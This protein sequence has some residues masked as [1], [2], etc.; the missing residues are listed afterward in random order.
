MITINL[1]DQGSAKGRPG[2]PA[3]PG[4]RPSAGGGG[5]GSLLTILALL[6]ALGI[7]GAAGWFGYQNYS[8]AHK[9]FAAIKGEHD[10]VQAE[11]ANKENEA[12]SVRKY[13]E[14]VENQLDVLNSLDP[15]DR[16]LWA[17]KLNML[18]GLMPTNV[19]LA[20]IDVQ[21]K[22][23]MV[24]TEQSKQA[25]AK[26]QKMKKAEKDKTKE[27][28]IVTKP[29]ISY[30]VRLTGLASGKDNVEQFDNMM[31]FHRAMTEFETVAN[32]GEARRFM[33]NFNPNI[34]FEK[35]EATVYEGVP[36][37]QFVFKLTTKLMGQDN[38]EP[39]G[40]VATPAKTSKKV[41]A[42]R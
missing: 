20:E 39:A 19:F 42:A 31:K 2:K 8:S 25:R 32:S 23:T 29:V 13:R 1:L 10:K 16:I 21:E 36:V 18:S 26:W 35:V 14:V 24:E 38:P 28:K 30:V 5:G 41:A 40:E 4:A 15:A 3:A 12:E 7:N 22:V 37:N 34:E 27:P 9:R 17:E 11:I 6:F 33:D